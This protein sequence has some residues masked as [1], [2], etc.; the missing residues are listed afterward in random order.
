MLSGLLAGLAAVLAIQAAVQPA[1]TTEPQTPPAE[2]STELPDVI[3]HGRSLRSEARA[4]VAEVGAP[5]PR[6]T[7]A[8]W[9]DAICVGV[10]NLRDDLSSEILAHVAVQAQAV[11]VRV[12]P[13]PCKPNV[14]VIA[15]DAP[16]AT[17]R[18]LIRAE[19]S[20][21][22]PTRGGTDLGLSALNRFRDSDAPIRWWNVAMP[23]SNDTG[24]MAI[25]LDAQAGESPPVV[26]D[27]AV[28]RLQSTVRSDM[29]WVMVIIDVTKTGQTPIGALSDYV[30]MLV[31]A[32]IDADADMTGRDTI[33]N[34]FND[35]GAVDAITEWDRGY[36]Q[37]L[38]GSPTGRPGAG[39]QAVDIERS[40]I[41]GQRDSQ[42]SQPAAETS[43]APRP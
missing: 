14:L 16:D 6:S 20:Y 36:L 8:R 12:R 1:Q 4:Y 26:A 2:T 38:Y 25:A 19:P 43:P 13:Q 3:V 42:L 35:P 40:M 37:G 11:G 7:L 5:V 23:V 30:A 9:H 31:L 32:Q 15:T 17:A 27:R 29:A 24:A 10:V 34:L 41:I 22:R 18:G 39:R 28:S 21:F 33:L